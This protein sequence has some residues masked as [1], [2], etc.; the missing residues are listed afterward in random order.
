ME[1][2]FLQSPQTH[3][4]SLAPSESTGTRIVAIYSAAWTSVASSCPLD[5]R[6]LARPRATATSWVQPV[7]FAWFF[8]PSSL[9]SAT[10]RERFLG[11][12]ALAQVAL[13]SHRGWP[14][15]AEMEENLRDGA[16]WL[17]PPS[18]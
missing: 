17:T 11:T 2:I 14:T 3:F 6:H 15:V 8:S 4:G 10:C 16:K 1:S 7:C 13:R 18:T 5:L 12:G 9:H